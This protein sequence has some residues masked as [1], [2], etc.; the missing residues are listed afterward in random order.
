MVVGL[1][2]HYAEMEK[3][4][5]Q[6][7]HRVAYLLT[8]EDVAEA[9]EFLAAGEY[10]LALEVIAEGLRAQKGPS[11]DPAIVQSIAKLAHDMGIESRPFVKALLALQR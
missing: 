6:L 4:L 9:M 3:E 2:T 5:R 1:A 11:I 10:G 7:L 8:K